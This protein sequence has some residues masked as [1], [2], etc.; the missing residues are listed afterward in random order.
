MVK[1][2]PNRLPFKDLTQW[3]RSTI[4]ASSSHWKGYCKNSFRRH[5]LL[6]GYS[7]GVPPR[8]YLA[9]NLIDTLKVRNTP[10]P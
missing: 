6:G 8:L 2:K 9:H 3:F 7:D 1:D 10:L 4:L 5:L